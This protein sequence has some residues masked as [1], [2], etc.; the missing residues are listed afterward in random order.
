MVKRVFCALCVFAVLLS[1][2]FRV[3]AESNVYSKNASAGKKVAITFDDG[4]H[5]IY[6]K[7]ILDILEKY[8][9]R[10]TFFVIGRNIENYPEAFEELAKSDNEIGNHTYN[11]K[12][13]GGLGRTRLESEIIMT[14]RLIESYSNRHSSVLRPPEGD[15]G[16][17]LNE[18]SLE[19]GYDIVLWSIDTLDW[20]H[21][22]AQKMADTVLGSVGDGDIILMHDYTSHGA[23]TC[24]AL[25]IIIPR[26][27]EMGYELVTVSELI[28]EE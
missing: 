11:H 22:P 27:I 19:E 2:S 26:L 9:A 8:G 4:P 24:E 15:F 20:A 17:L 16:E 12:R 14:E 10:A 25:E 3:S 6:T 7:R 28:C 5:P 18:I 1:F 23:H 21:T 13:L